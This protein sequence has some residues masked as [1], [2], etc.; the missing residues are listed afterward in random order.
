MW[1]AAWCVINI[2]QGTFSGLVNDEAYYHIYT[3]DL[4]WGY[5]DHPP[6]LALLIWLGEA[7]CGV[8]QIGMR[9]FVI[10]LQPLYIWIFWKTIAPQ[11]ATRKDAALYLMTFASI[12]MMQP[13]GFIAVPDAPLMFSV[14]LFLWAYKA[15][16]ENK[17]YAWWWLGFTMATMAY[18][19]YQGALVVFF[20]IVFNIRLL[21]NPKFYLSGIVALVLF[22]PHLLWQYQNDFPSFVYHL[23]E[24]NS[25][26]NWK[27]VSE[28]L[29]NLIAVFNIFFIPLWV[30]A[31]R[32]IKAQNLFERA[33]KWIP[34]AIF[35]FFL[36]SSVRGRTQ[37]QWMIASTYGLIWLLFMYGREHARTRRYIMRVGWGILFVIA[38]LRLEIIFNV[39]GL[40][41]K[42]TMAGNEEYY[43]AIYDVAQERPVIFRGNYAIAAKYIIYTP[44]EGYCTP[45]IGYRTHQWQFV[46]DDEFAGREVLVEYTPTKAERKA[47]PDKYKSITLPNGKVFRY[48]ELKNYIPTKRV[49]I[50]PTVELPTLLRRGE[51]IEINLMIE[52]PY[53][54]ELTSDNE[55]VRLLMILRDE[56]KQPH[57][58][59]IKEG[60][61][62]GEESTLLQ[63]FTVEIPKEL[64]RGEY[65]VGFSIIGKQMNG[66]F[67]APPHKIM[68]D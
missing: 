26:F 6:F 63:R 13:Y 36:F 3:R 29:L 30:Q 20:A 32:K 1:L 5:Y 22:S 35:I 51:E 57:Y 41:E 9:L 68:I 47:N 7:L 15:F 62:M 23:S 55:Q 66:W 42:Q 17:Q 37:P 48:Y 25:D 27:S 54:R 18:S 59:N 60:V 50:T 4:A 11:G 28:F 56:N 31:Y 65:Q 46:S 14:A 38:L 45:S 10:V 49:K 19:K 34:L 24:R 67:S 8:T 61:L 40:S 58:I 43:G 64:K 16:L 2:I 39:L 44:G 12:I 21:L 52:N 53:S 33:L